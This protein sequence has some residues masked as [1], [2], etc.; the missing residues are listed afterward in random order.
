MKTERFNIVLRSMAGIPLAFYG[1]AFQKAWI[2]IES[3]PSAALA[4]HIDVLPGGVLNALLAFAFG[5]LALKFDSTRFRRNALAIGVALQLCTAALLAVSLSFGFHPAAL[6]I[7]SSLA[8]VGGVV[9]LSALWIDLYSLL[10]PVRVAY[11]N[12]VT[13]IV[14]QALIFVV[15]GNELWRILPVMAVLS[16]IT[17]LLYLLA[18]RDGRKE[19][20]PTP[21][22]KARFLFPYKAVL[23]I[24]VYSF[25]YGIAS[26]G[27]NVVSARY[28]A[29]V[30]A[31]IV[32]AFIFLN[33]RRFNISMLLRLAFPLM[34]AGFLLVSLIP[35]EVRSV[36]SFMLSSGFSAMEMLLV[37]IVCTIAYSSGTSAIWLFGIL[38][39]TQ[40]LARAL[41]SSFGAFAHSELGGSEFTAISVVVIVLVILA[42]LTL[43]SEK[44]LFSV[45]GGFKSREAAGD[46][47]P[48]EKDE[49]PAES[50][51]MRI[52]TISAAYSLTDRE[53]EVFYLAMKGKSNAQIGRDM[54]I[55]VGTVKAHLYHIYQ[56][57]G[58]HTRKELFALVEKRK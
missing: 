25:A 3:V 26:Q 34:V 7:A 29:V 21:V 58:I 6:S 19:Q 40:F 35:G 49:A 15:E 28:T 53:T 32:L 12:A 36:S 8:D 5:F 1:Y 9:L 45:W 10:N 27:I 42:S 16:C 24:A 23:F 56:K 41:G 51:E 18:A 38:G 47:S 55:S 2:S 33:T 39:G 43:M 57:L 20:P 31:I 48:S 11:L 22:S 37:L 54:F 52:N 13:I 44:S 50:L 4:P 17:A 14:A 46:G 30:P